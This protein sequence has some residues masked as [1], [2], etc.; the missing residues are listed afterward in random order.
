MSFAV[1]AAVATIGI[2]A[3]GVVNAN[4]ARKAGKNANAA[5]LKASVA[6]AEEE[7]KTM[8]ELALSKLEIE[9][10]ALVAAQNEASETRK[11]KLL[12]GAGALVAVAIGAGAYV[13]VKKRK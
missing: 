6:L 2:G 11:T 1:V 12:I 13:V 4:K 9:R 8:E 7:A 10:A 3:A 5:G